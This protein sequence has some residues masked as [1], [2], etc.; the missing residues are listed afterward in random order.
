MSL[1]IQIIRD[2][3][4]HKCENTPGLY[5]QLKINYLKCS[6]TEVPA[7]LWFIMYLAQFHIVAK[8]K[9]HKHPDWP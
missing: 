9:C 3:R 7:D 8:Q 4:T 2:W 6:D 1:S 5:V